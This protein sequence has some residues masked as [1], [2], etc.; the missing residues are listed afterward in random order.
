MTRLAERL[1]EGL[2][3]YLAAGDLRVAIVGLSGEALEV[4]EGAESLGAAAAIFDPQ[5]DPAI[6]PR[7]LPWPELAGF[8]P[9]V[10]VIASDEGKEELLSA[11][12]S[13]FDGTP[14]PHCVLA[15][16]GHQDRT[17]DSLFEQLEAPALVPSYAT[18]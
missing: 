7:L 13:V 11:A 3:S 16:L 4:L 8:Q 5:A 6:H 14:I 1:L 12:A 10:V 18:G 17:E 2:S 15:G 9:Q